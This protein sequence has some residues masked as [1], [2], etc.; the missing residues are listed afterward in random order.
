MRYFQYLSIFVF[1]ISASFIKAQEISIFP[2]LFG[3]EFY[4]DDHRVTKKE[5][6]ILMEENKEANKLWKKAKSYSIASKGLA[7]VQVGLA[8]YGISSIYNGKG[9][10]SLKPLYASIGV[11]LIGIILNTK[12]LTNRKKSILSYNKAFDSKSKTYLTPSDSGIGICLNF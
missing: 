10:E 12:A 11:G 1:V 6:S 2:G 4:V 5:V 3:E 7:V 9:K 8:Y